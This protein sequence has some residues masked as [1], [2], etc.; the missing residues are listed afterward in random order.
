MYSIRELLEFNSDMMK[1][2]FTK[3]LTEELLVFSSY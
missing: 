1:D 2:I 3:T